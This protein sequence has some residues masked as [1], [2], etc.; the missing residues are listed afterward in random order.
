MSHIAIEG[1]QRQSR[2]LDGARQRR[3]YRPDDLDAKQTTNPGYCVKCQA[4]R[5]MTDTKS[6]KRGGGPALEG[7]CVICGG[8]SLLRIADRVVVRLASSRGI[9][10]KRTHVIERRLYCFLE[11]GALHSGIMHRSPVLLDDRR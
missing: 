4:T 9:A 8:T 2:R 10:P 5:E 7:K 11:L 1:A 6:I 3:K